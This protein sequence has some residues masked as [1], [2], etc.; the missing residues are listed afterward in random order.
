MKTLTPKWEI[1]TW[2]RILCPSCEE[3][4]FELMYSDESH[5]L[6]RLLTR[7]ISKPE[8]FLCEDCLKEEENE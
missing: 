4:I 8:A 1:G 7:Y 2:I 3:V 5:E 6:I